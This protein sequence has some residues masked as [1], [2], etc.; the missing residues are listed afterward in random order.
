MPVT[1]S[2]MSI[3][4]FT[5]IAQDWIAQARD[6]RWHRPFTNLVHR[7]MLEVVDYLR[8]KGF[9]TYI[10]TGGGQEFVRVCRRVYGIPPEQVVGLS[11]LTR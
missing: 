10:V 6:P 11:I 7:P 8:A 1:H 4:A 3:E 2:G 5:A 9:K